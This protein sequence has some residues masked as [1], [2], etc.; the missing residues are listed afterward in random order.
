MKPEILDGKK[1]NG[2]IYGRKGSYS[3]YL[4]GE[5][6]SASDELAGELEKWV[7]EM[8]GYRKKRKEIL[9]E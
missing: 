3:I 1:W 7:E 9:E 5:K 8:E 4:D 2:K 6:T